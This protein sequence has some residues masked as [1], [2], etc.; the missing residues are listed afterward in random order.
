MSDIGVDQVIF[1]QQAGRNRHADI[2]DSLE[3]FASEVMPEFIADD[4]GREQR[5]TEALAP[6]VEAALGRK[7]WM[8]PLADDEIPVVKASVA[9]AQTSGRLA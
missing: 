8:R 3:L 6:F 1:I 2:C 7:H 9:K 4:A 5:K